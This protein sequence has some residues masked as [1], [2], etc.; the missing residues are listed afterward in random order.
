VWV[1][2][3]ASNPF[4]CA[5]LGAFVSITAMVIVSLMTEPPSEEHLKR[6]F[7]T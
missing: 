6:V 5:T 3:Q 7:G 2:S 1:A 4:A